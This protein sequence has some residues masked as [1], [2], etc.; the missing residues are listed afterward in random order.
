MRAVAPRSEVLNCS[1]PR[2]HVFT[3]QN[4]LFPT[5]HLPSKTSSD[6]QTAIHSPRLRDPGSLHV[7]Y[8]LNTAAYFERPLAIGGGDERDRA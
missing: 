3:G 8:R 7:P 5:V 2:S 4:I 6:P 1:L